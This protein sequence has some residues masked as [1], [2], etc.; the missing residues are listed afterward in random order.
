MNKFEYRT[1]F[2]LE[3]II[4]NIL[5]YILGVL[6]CYFIIWLNYSFFFERQDWIIK[7]ALLKYL[8]SNELKLNYI[9]RYNNQI[10]LKY[11]F[12]GYEL[13][14]FEYDKN[15]GLYNNKDDCILASF[16]SGI[17]DKKIVNKIKN[18]IQNKNNEIIQKMTNGEPI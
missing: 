17:F 2:K 16:A 15:F 8:N 4:F 7:K 18:I 9:P 13:I 12:E 14:W 3:N 11:N 5:G 10:I 6:S 1:I